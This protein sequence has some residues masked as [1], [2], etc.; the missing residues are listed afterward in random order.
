M[1][2]SQINVEL[3]ANFYNLAD[4]KPEMERNIRVIDLTTIPQIRSLTIE[5]F[6]TDIVY[7][8]V[9]SIKDTYLVEVG[10]ELSMWSHWDGEFFDDEFIDLTEDDLPFIYW[11]YED[12]LQFKLKA[13]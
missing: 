9:T 6:K 5:E 8:N 10:G 2:A 1:K 4:V 11:C 12:N 13:L 3:N 7:A